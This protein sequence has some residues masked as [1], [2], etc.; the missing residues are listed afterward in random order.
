MQ[1]LGLRLSGPASSG[2]TPLK[3]SSPPQ[4]G[5]HGL[6]QQHFTSSQTYI[7]TEQ[8]A[9]NGA[10]SSGSVTVVGQFQP[11]AALPESRHSDEAQLKEKKGSHHGG[12]HVRAAVRLSAAQTQPSLRRSP[13]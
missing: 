9:L 10:R 12:V 2:S 8:G 11:V 1:Q 5:A 3:S 4:H 7:C 6:Q 13:E